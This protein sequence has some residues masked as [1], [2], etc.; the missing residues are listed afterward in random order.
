MLVLGG[1]M[2]AVRGRLVSA[3]WARR[4][5][6][7]FFRGSLGVL[8]RQV[9][10]WLIVRMLTVSPLL[11]QGPLF[12][13]RFE[14][15]PTDLRIAGKIVVSDAEGLTSGHLDKLWEDAGQQ[16]WSLM[17]TLPAAA[18]LP[19]C[20]RRSGESVNIWSVNADP[21]TIDSFDVLVWEPGLASEV[22]TGPHRDK[23]ESLAR[24]C[25]RA[26]KG[27]WVIGS[28]GEWLSQV[29]VEGRAT[30]PPRLIPGVHLLPDCLLWM[31]AEYSPQVQQQLA[32]NLKSSPRSVG[33][34]LEPRT[35]LVLEGRQ[36]RV[37]GEGR[38]H[39]RLAANHRLPV[40]MASI[41]ERRQ[42]NAERPEAW[43]IDLTEWRR[44]GIERTLEPFPPAQRIPPDSGGGTLMILGGG[45]LPEGLMEEFV[46]RAGGPEQA[47]LVY[48]PCSEA[49]TVEV[50]RGM[51]PSW[52]AM[53]VKQAFQLHT[54]DRLQADRDEQ[55]LAPLRGATGIWFGGGRQW[56]F[57]DSYYGTTAHR[58]M[59]EVLQRG[60]VIGG[61][62]AGASIQASYLARATPIGN[63]Q[64]LAPGY[65]RG[66]LGF[67][68]GVA[69]DQHFTQRRRQPDLSGLIDR[70][71]QLLGIGID[72]TTALVVQASIGKVQGEGHVYFYDRQPPQN[73][74]LPDY[75][76]L[77]DGEF[78]DL[79]QRRRVEGPRG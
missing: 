79:V 19:E 43:L 51:V 76:R 29:V 52:Q 55:F 64:I 22:L 17:Q 45:R 71:P 34:V 5:Q 7:W 10:G 9:C 48:V 25:L 13:E 31:R 62:S 12:D 23:I 26:G 49:E 14:D 18:A 24:E 3:W 74:G 21:P 36:C 30:A 16:R 69:I 8:G 73:T 58:L 39:F 15:W 57:A 50:S 59:K 61:S 75:L 77:G 66:G 65:E 37:V 47:R 46:L 1:W 44:D 38:A 60:G 41:A 32:E 78:Y 72:E 33:I 63:Q 28:P 20:L 4:S 2:I 70:Y 42:G 54:K 35:S 56:N 68:R 27:L 6:R 40:R 11:A 53:G 67:I